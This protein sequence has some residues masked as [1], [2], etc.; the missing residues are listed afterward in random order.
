MGLS[1]GG[2]AIAM[3]VR[4]LP[5]RCPGRWEAAGCSTQDLCKRLVRFVDTDAF[6]V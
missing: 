3:R 1:E 2:F 4:E 6:D 5:P